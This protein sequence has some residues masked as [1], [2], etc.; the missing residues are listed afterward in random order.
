MNGGMFP[1]SSAIAIILISSDGSNRISRTPVK[2]FRCFQNFQKISP[3]T[4][5]TKMNTAK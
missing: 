5:A 4:I 2:N 3:S 1:C